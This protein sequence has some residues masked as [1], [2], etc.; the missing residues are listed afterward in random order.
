MDEFEMK[1]EDET[2]ATFAFPVV[3]T[4][5]VISLLLSTSIDDDD[6][7]EGKMGYS[8]VLTVVKEAGVRGRGRVVNDVVE[9]PS[10]ACVLIP[11][12][13][14]S[15]IPAVIRS[16]TEYMEEVD[17]EYTLVEEVA[18]PEETEV[19]GVVVEVAASTESTV[20]CTV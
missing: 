11:S 1:T 18:S 17:K 10:T 2:E 12:P 9:L 8:R 6:V 15:A 7:D 16:Y 3:I 20:Y 4:S 13:F 5:V 19:V 14:T